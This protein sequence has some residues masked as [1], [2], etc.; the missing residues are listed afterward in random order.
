M[1]V[2]HSNPILS[3]KQIINVNCPSKLGRYVPKIDYVILIRRILGTLLSK[4]K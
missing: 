4:V 3:T 1:T 2:Y